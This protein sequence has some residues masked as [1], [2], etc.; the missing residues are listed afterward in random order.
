[1]E[2]LSSSENYIKAS[3]PALMPMVSDS[4]FFNQIFSSTKLKP[5]GTFDA[6]AVVLSLGLVAKRINKMQTS[7]NAM[8]KYN[9]EYEACYIDDF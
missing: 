7:N 6:G 1:M 8:R 2:V 4:V 3:A 5:S 9:T